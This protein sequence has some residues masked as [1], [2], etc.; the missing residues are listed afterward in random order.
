[1]FTPNSNKWKRALRADGWRDKKLSFDISK[2]KERSNNIKNTFTLK[3]NKGHKWCNP[4]K[5]DIYTISI[6]AF[7][8]KGNWG[9][10]FPFYIW[11]Y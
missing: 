6:K 9:L 11:K 8:L 1:M 4:L 2:G 7:W 5:Y 3:Q 10:K